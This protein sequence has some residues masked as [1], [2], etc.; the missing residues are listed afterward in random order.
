MEL[1][2]WRGGHRSF[3][4][5]ITVTPRSRKAWVRRGE[6]TASEPADQGDWGRHLVG[7][8]DDLEPGRP[9]AAPVLRSQETGDHDGSN[10]S[11]YEVEGALVY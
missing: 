1:P 4:V 3:S 10:I 2:L 11:P 6:A 5:A 7:D 8:R 9:R